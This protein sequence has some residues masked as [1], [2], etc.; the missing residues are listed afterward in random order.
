V[1]IEHWTSGGPCTSKCSKQAGK[2]STHN[3]T[4]FFLADFELENIPLKLMN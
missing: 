2:P 3:I 4:K 1:K